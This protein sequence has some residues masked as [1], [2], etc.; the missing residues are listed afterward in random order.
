MADLSEKRMVTPPFTYSG[1][2]CFEPFY[3]KEGRQELSLMIWWECNCLI[4][5]L[6]TVYPHTIFGSYL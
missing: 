5:R 2:D 3:V 4:V 6:V 1:M